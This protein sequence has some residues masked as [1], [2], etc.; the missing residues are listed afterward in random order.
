MSVAFIISQHDPPKTAT[1]EVYDPFPNFIVILPAVDFVCP[2]YFPFAKTHADVIKVWV[3]ILFMLTI[4]LI[5][6]FETCSQDKFYRKT[7]SCAVLSFDKYS[8]GPSRYNF[9]PAVTVHGIYR[10]H[11]MKQDGTYIAVQQ[12]HQTIFE[13]LRYFR[14]IVLILK[15]HSVITSLLLS[16][17]Y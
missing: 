5:A 14:D 11:P 12:F 13:Y 9:T 7:H 17:Y 2:A 4:D 3:I 15:S 6:S 16:Q 10:H 8:R 1:T